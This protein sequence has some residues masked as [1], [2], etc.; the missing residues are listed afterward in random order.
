VKV[1]IQASKIIQ[2][3]TCILDRSQLVTFTGDPLK[4]ADLISQKFKGA[5]NYVQSDFQVFSLLMISTVMQDM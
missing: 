1:Y 3:I 4:P 5:R 2:L